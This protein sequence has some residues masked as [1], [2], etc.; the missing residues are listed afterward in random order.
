VKF[1]EL[2]S[3]QLRE[4]VNTR[5]RYEAWREAA[6]RVRTFRGSMVWSETKGHEYLMRAAY[7]KHG[8][9]RQS[10]LGVRGRE[11]EKIK[12]EYER[13]REAARSRLAELEP[14]LMRQAAINRA[15]GLG[16][17][18]RLG[19]KIIRA[20]DEHRLLG[21]GLRVLG[22]FSLYAY[23]AVAGVQ[24]DPS[25]STTEDIDLLLDARGGVSL[26]AT[27]EFE[28]K[29][30]IRILRRIDKSFERSGQA[31]RAVNR[32]GFLVDLIKPLP[33][34]PWSKEADRIGGDPEDLA[35][36][37][38]EGLAWHES[39]P[40]FEASAIDERGEPLRIVTTDPRVFAAHKYWLSQRS[41]REPFKRRR[42]REQ[43]EVVASLVA[44]HLAHLP[45]EEDA[46][47]MLPRDLVDQVRPLF[48]RPDQREL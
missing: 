1:I 32:D 26:A 27:E 24:I 14:V 44:L 19:A 18:P 7:D 17:V 9:R 40:P 48:T 8:R 15:V 21:S 41:D 23:E 25:V 39:A 22:T 13:G 10:S 6:A 3:D 4:Y 36:V 35:A 47:R 43:A 30:L 12:A 5:Q 34:P 11:T 20:L 29:S 42:D 37:E 38:I 31:F 2:N 33:N 46:L 45:F 16:R 28:S